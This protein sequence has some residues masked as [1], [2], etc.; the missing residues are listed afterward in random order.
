MAQ[1]SAVTMR[2]KLHAKILAS[3]PLSPPPPPPSSGPKEETETVAR[4]IVIKP[5]IV[6]EAKLIQ[7]VA[8]AIDRA[9]EE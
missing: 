1:E 4:P 8:A 7:A 9:E 5:V 2:Q 6:S 3:V